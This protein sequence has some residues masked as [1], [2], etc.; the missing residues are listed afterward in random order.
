MPSS[1]AKSPSPEFPDRAQ[2][3]LRPHGTAAAPDTPGT[4]ERWSKVP[5]VTVYFW[6]IKILCTTVGETAADYLNVNLNFGLRG[7]SVVTGILLAVV[8]AAQFRARRYVPALYWTAVALVSVFGTLVT[9]NLTDGLGVPLQLSTI[10]F[11]V[12]LA[13]V[14]GA[15]YLSERTLSIHSIITRRRE[16]F[17]WLAILFT[18]ALGTAAGDLMSEGLGLGYSRTGLIVGGLILVGALAWR[19]GLNPVLSFWIIYIL[20]RPLGASLG[21][22]LSQPGSHGGLGVGV[23]L[24]SIIFIVG[25]L[26]I[27]GYLSVSRKDVVRVPVRTPAEH[28]APSRHGVVQTAVVV[29]LVVAASVTGYNLR[30]SALQAEAASSAGL[31]AAGLTAAEVSAQVP[32]LGDMTVFRTITRDT[33]GLIDA[34]DQ[35]GATGRVADLEYEWDNAQARLKPRSTEQWGR[36]DGAIDTVLRDLRAA[37]PDPAAEKTALGELLAL[38]A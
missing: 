38:L 34:G 20:T 31:T 6:I 29:G 37:G 12:L 13:A 1:A 2:T 7:T 33:L 18:F 36:V 26:V 21:D 10:V 5:E 22:Y 19:L 24:T 8:L 32:A 30:H 15:W 23:T 25:I 3:R 9:D 16:V 4:L 14:F 28:Q 11:A 35:A 17:Y 27:V